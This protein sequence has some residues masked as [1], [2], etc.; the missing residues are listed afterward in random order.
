MISTNVRG[1]L[2][3]P[4]FLKVPHHFGQILASRRAFRAEYP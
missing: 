4:V 3:V 1:K 2:F